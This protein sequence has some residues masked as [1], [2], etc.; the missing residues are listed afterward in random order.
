MKIRTAYTLT[1]ACDE[2]RNRYK[3]EKQKQLELLETIR[4]LR[5]I[6]K[7]DFYKDMESGSENDYDVVE[8]SENTASAKHVHQRNGIVDERNKD[9]VS[10]ERKE[11][12]GSS[13]QTEGKGSNERNADTGSNERNADTGSNE[14]NADTGSNERNEHQLNNEL[15]VDSSIDTERILSPIANQLLTPERVTSPE[16]IMSTANPTPEPESIKTSPSPDKNGDTPDN[17][18]VAEVYCENHAETSEENQN[19]QPNNNET[20]VNSDKGRKSKKKYK[21]KRYSIV[22][23][24]TGCRIDT[25]WPRGHKLFTKPSLDEPYSPRE[26]KECFACYEQNNR[27]PLPISK[28]SDGPSNKQHEVKVKKFC[29]EHD[30]WRQTLIRIA[31]EKEFEYLKK[32]SLHLFPFQKSA[33]DTMISLDSHRSKH[34]HSKLDSLTT[35]NHTQRG[36]KT[37]LRSIDIQRPIKSP[38]KPM[39]EKIKELKFQSLHEGSQPDQEIARTKSGHAS[40][41]QGYDS[42]E[43]S[44][45]HNSKQSYEKNN[46]SNFGLYPILRKQK[47]QVWKKL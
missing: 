41:D 1:S 27:I 5:G 21:K 40:N 13:E 32:Q 39:H 15:Y 4:Q 7:D 18:I 31:Y 37:Y 46:T 33:L 14:R 16:C 45:D 34:T 30:A 8:I 26:H 3:K 22:I 44:L 29:K 17:V 20:D 10:N 11:G 24:T 28:H 19:D 42:G 23:K 6:S 12:N 47:L 2:L 38:N 35:N 9:T 43:E 36:K 25:R